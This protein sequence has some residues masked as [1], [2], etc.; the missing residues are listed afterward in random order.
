MFKVPIVRRGSA[1][2]SY[3]PH[4]QDKN[5]RRAHRINLFEKSLGKLL[6]LHPYRCETCDGRYYILGRRRTPLQDRRGS[7][8]NSPQPL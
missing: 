6:S 2:S 3:C 8:S 7:P 5:V 4:C 1:A